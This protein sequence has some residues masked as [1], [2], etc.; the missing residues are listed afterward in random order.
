MLCVVSCRLLFQ[1]LTALK[2]RLDFIIRRQ[3][4]PHFHEN[5]QTPITLNDS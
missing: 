4:L 2:N 3:M 5:R 1:A